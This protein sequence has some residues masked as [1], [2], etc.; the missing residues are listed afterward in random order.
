VG[1]LEIKAEV[2]FDPAS[3]TPRPVVVQIHGG[4]LM[5]GRR[6]AGPGRLHKRL[7]DAGCVVSI[8]YRLAPETKLLEIVSDVVDAHAWVRKEG[9]ALFGADPKRVATTGWSAGGYLTLEPIPQVGTP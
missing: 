5:V 6:A 3:R 4:A 9:P 2:F 1:S 8:D 7:I